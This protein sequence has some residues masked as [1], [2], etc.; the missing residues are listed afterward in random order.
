MRII[1]GTHKRRKLKGLELS[2]TRPTKDRVKESIFNMLSTSL[3]KTH[4]L[5]LFAGSGALGLEALSRGVK[6][7]TFV[8]HDQTAQKVIKDNLDA[9]DLKNRAT[10]RCEKALDFLAQN[11]TVFDLVMLD[12]PYN[13]GLIPQV[14]DKLSVASYLS[15]DVIIVILSEKNLSLKAYQTLK[16]VKD[17]TIG[18]T[19]VMFLKKEA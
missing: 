15:D 12:P 7:A 17:K 5:D 1:A 19:K 2:H 16:V 10:V 3:D 14:L 18:I 9:L 4:V 13:Q 11:E 6:R 8:D